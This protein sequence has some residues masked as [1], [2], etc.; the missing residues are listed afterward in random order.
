MH[1]LYNL[2]KV[3]SIGHSTHSLEYFLTLIETHDINTLIDVR[4][5]PASNYNPQFNKESFEYFLK[6][7]GIN[8]MHFR[9]EFG[10][11][12]SDSNF[13]DDSGVL[14]F[15]KFRESFQFQQGIERI[16]IG[17]S[18]GYKIVLMCSESNPLECHRFSMISVYLESI[19][20]KVNHIMRDGTCKNHSELEKDLLK[21]YNKKLPKPDLFDQNIDINDQLEVAYKLHNKEIGWKSEAD[22]EGDIY[23]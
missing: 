22:K 12:Q 9:D 1:K 3:Y 23:R 15:D 2:R 21:K 5:V 17:I 16:D 19:D 6:D 10:A 8:Y 7:N 18:K 20:I 4:S 13:L 11:R 14:N